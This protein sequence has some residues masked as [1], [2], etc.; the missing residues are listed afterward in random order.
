[1]RVGRSSG[2][3][4]TRSL[5]RFCFSGKGATESYIARDVSMLCCAL[6]KISLFTFLGSEWK[7]AG[8]GRKASVA[9][10]SAIQES[11]DGDREVGSD[12]RGGRGSWIGAGLGNG[13]HLE[14]KEW[15]EGSGE[16]P[17]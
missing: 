12:C 11:G 6:S 5:R 9:A 15:G 7:G 13:L 2:L 14:S 3:A 1:M 4:C 10:L 8:L 16:G 17:E